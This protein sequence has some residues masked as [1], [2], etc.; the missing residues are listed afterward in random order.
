MKYEF[1]EIVADIK[2]L[3]SYFTE[4]AA[5]YE[6]DKPADISID[7]APEDFDYERIH[8]EK[9]VIFPDYYLEPL[10]I[11]RKFCEYAVM[12]DVVLFHSSAVCVDG[13][14][15]VF[16]APSG[17]GKSTHARLWKEMLG[18]RM[19]YIN[20]DKP[21]IR[22][23]DGRFFI[24]GTP[25]NGKHRL[26]NNTS[27]P[28]RAITFLSQSPDNHIE[29]MEKGMVLPYLLT[30]TYKTRQRAGTEKVLALDGE[31]AL[32]VPV[33]KMGCNISAEAARMSYTAMKGMNDL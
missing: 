32:T 2:P 25:W 9:G 10:A 5:G 33:L 23:K 12:E 26:S 14:A 31:M 24:Y 1:A 7:I 6:T 19:T 15:Y 13:E 4:M 22:K 8:A 30:Q 16:T 21:L 20:D 27:A 29:P 3:Y 18:D 11:Y 28:I 17:T